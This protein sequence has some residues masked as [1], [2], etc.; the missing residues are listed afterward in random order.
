MRATKIDVV[1]IKHIS[2]SLT[3]ELDRD[4]RWNSIIFVRASGTLSMISCKDF[5]SNDIK[6]ASTPRI[7]SVLYTEKNT[8][9]KANSSIRSVQALSKV[10]I[11]STAS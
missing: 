10:S 4:K 6:H 5:F 9:D 11:D 1:S 7:T 8:F 2:E 3:S